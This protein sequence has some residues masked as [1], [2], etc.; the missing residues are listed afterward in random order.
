MKRLHRWATAL[1]RGVAAHDPDRRAYRRSALRIGLRVAVVSAALVFAVVVLVVVYVLWQLT[2]AQQLERHGP[3]DVHVYL[4]TFDLL[5]AVLVVGSASVVLA[6]VATWLIAGRAVRPLAEAYRLQRTFVADASH[7][8]RTPLTVLSA[9]AQQLQTMLP[10]ATTERAVADALRDDTRALAD[11]V[12]DLLAM[13]AGRSDERAEALLDAAL[14]AAADEMAVLARDRNVHLVVTPGQA[15]LRVTPTQLRRCLVALIDNA[16]GHS[17][18]GGAVWVDN[19]VVGDRVVIRVRDEGAG[20]TGI[21]PRRVFDRFAHGSP[22]R[23]GGPT[24]TSN[25]I[26]LAL[27]RDI[28]VRAGGDVVVERTGKTGTVFALT[29]PRVRHDVETRRRVGRGPGA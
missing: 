20:I 24:R 28:A 26:G 29:L 16:I 12:D 10:E 5:I 18:D 14:A 13:A 17:P 7:E 2:P 15:L 8:L 22:S 25:G 19:E 23:S 27:V 11:V 21:A 3:E 9:R 1:V 4:D 6:G